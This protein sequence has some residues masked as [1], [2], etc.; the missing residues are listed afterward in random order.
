L[1][2]YGTAAAVV[3][4]QLFFTDLDPLAGTLASQPGVRF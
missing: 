3:F 2:L 1:L 4:N